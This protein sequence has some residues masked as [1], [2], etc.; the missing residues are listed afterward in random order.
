MQKGGLAGASK[1]HSASIATR[2]P[3][4]GMSQVSRA[5]AGDFS[6]AQASWLHHVAQMNLLTL[7]ESEAQQTDSP[8]GASHVPGSVL[9]DHFLGMKEPQ[10][11]R[12]T[13]MEKTKSFGVKWV[14]FQT[15]ILPFSSCL[16]MAAS[17]L[18]L[19]RS[20]LNGKW[21]C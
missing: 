5:T 20:F 9:C 16:N 10:N 12:A 13:G 15:P 21:G 18:S 7:C 14:S 6:G 19:T 17:L 2:K 3:Q 4:H 8:K 1:N 11:H